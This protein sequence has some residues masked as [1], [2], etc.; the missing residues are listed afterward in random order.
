M[1]KQLILV[2][3]L[4]YVAGWLCALHKLDQYLATPEL[5]R[6]INFKLEDNATSPP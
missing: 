1:Q 6:G 3:R 2:Q 4:V 5:R